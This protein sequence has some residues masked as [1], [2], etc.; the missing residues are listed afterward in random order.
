M[1]KLTRAARRAAATFVFAGAGTLVGNS[2]FDV[3]AAVWKAAAGVGIGALINLVYRWAEAVLK[4]PEP[5]DVP[6]GNI[7]NKGD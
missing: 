2:I 1:T 7:E 6:G 3:D 4:E 5:V